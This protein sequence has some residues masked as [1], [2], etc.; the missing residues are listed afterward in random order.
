MS[1]ASYLECQEK[2]REIAEQR[3]T[4]IMLEAVFIGLL[5]W[6]AQIEPPQFDV[7]HY[8]IFSLAVFRTARLVSFNEVAEPFRAAFCEVKPDDCGAGENVHPRGRGA[9]YV[10]GSLLACPICSGTWAALVLY[11]LY[12]IAPAF[13]WMLAIVLALAGASELFHWAGECLEWGG[14]AAR[15]VSGLISPDREA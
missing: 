10:I 6:L 5:A 8:L 4:K 13:G 1:A 14:R 9:R 3:F 7:F 12:V 15:C 11:A 2:R